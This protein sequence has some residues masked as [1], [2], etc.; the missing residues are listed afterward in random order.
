MPEPYGGQHYP[1]EY[2][3]RGGLFPEGF[4]WGMGTAAYQIEGAY[5]EGGRGASIWDTF[6]GA[7]TVGMTGSMCKD[8]P[9]P[10]NP[11]MQATGATGNVANDHYHRY[12]ASRGCFS[13][14]RVHCASS[15]L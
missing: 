12:F 8:V 1:T 5:N 6:T 2:T 13:C 4:V 10:I 11:G 9:C 3:Y 7:N 15:M 14:C